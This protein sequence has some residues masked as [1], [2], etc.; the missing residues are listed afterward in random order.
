[1]L[2]AKNGDLLRGRLTDVTDGHVVFKSRHEDCVIPRERLT[3]II[4]LDGMEDAD[5]SEQE[6]VQAAVTAVLR[7][8]TT[9]T[10]IP[11]LVR[12]EKL[13]GQSSLFGRCAIPLGQIYELNVGQ[14]GARLANLAYA[15][16]KLRPAEAP[17]FAVSAPPGGSSASTTQDS[18]F[19]TES[20]R[21]SLE[22]AATNYARDSP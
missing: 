9:L 16:W 10:L 19:G 13:V 8:G 7:G 22:P 4:C 6:P 12:N 14:A 21:R 18:R 15:D 20:S 17:R 1:V 5:S 3:S 2:V 11:E